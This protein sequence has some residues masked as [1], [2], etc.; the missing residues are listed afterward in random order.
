MSLRIRTLHGTDGSDVKKKVMSHLNE[1]LANDARFEDFTLESINNALGN[2]EKPL[3]KETLDELEADGAIVRK[4]SNHILYILK[5]EEKSTHLQKFNLEGVG[6]W[7]IKRVVTGILI[8]VFL[9]Q[10]FYPT[11]V[12]SLLMAFSNNA[13]SLLSMIFA[14]GLFLPHILGIL[15]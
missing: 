10:F 6:D 2:I 7:Y 3:V 9:F 8:E 5:E 11:S 13:L 15:F 1:R 12:L 4:E 14:L